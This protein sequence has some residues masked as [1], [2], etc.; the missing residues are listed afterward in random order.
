MNPATATALDNNLLETR[1]TLLEKENLELKA[2]IEAL[3]EKPMTDE[4]QAQVANSH[5]NTLIYFVTF[6][7]LED[8]FRYGRTRTEEVEKRIG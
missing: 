6:E 1:I 5:L 2:R 7:N 4:E 3:E 8:A